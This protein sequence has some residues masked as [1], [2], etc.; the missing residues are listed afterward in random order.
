MA[1]RDGDPPATRFLSSSEDL[2]HAKPQVT[3]ARLI[4]M[5][6]RIRPLENITAVA[7]DDLTED[8]DELYQLATSALHRLRCARAEVE[9]ARHS[10]ARRTLTTELAQL[11]SAEEVFSSYACD[12]RDCLHEARR[13]RLSV[14]R[15]RQVKSEF[16]DLLRLQQGV[17]AGLTVGSDWQSPLFAHSGHPTAGRH[18]G[19]VT[20]HFDDYKRDRHPQARAFEES[21]LREYVDVPSGLAVRALMTSCGMSAFTTILHFLSVTL[22]QRSPIVA[23]RGM[24]HECRGLLAD[25][26]LGSRVCWV[27]ETDTIEMLEACRRLQPG[28]LF[29]DSMCN[30]KGLPVPDTQALML[31]LATI[32]KR[33]VF[34]VI[35]NTCASLFCQPL[36]LA[37]LNPNVRPVLFESLTKYAQFGLDRVAAGMIVAPQ[38][39]AASLDGV[40]EHLGT[41]IA[42]VCAAI[43]PVPNRSLLIRRLRRIE[44]NAHALAQHL[45]RR[46]EG[47]TPVT[48]TT[49]PGLESHGGHSAARRLGF[50]GG[51]FAMEFRGECDCIA[52]HGRLVSRLIYEARRRRVNLG[53]GAGFG[54]NVTRV[55]RTA[56]ET[57]VGP[58]VRVA[59]GTEDMIEVERLKEVFASAIGASAR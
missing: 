47:T 10:Y 56:T 53:A 19:S 38:E 25:G 41:N 37:A 13:H 14:D 30:S 55:Y 48:G 54:F 6:Q 5:S 27:D 32:A 18:S 9:R 28:A 49:Y 42:D 57:G 16:A 31:E 50:F 24:Y 45:S 1:F 2:A 40:R 7:L 22:D 39:E 34:V 8:V 17:A 35:D 43:V 23:A 3:Q 29:L 36:R 46:G 58:F 15:L 11:R 21:Y 20:E 44:R 52:A 59:A 26:A 4:D 12:I 33:D 51:F